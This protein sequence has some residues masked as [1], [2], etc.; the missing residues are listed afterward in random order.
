MVRYLIAGLL[1]IGGC[2]NPDR[3]LALEYPAVRV[4]ASFRENQGE[5]EDVQ[6]FR[7]WIRHPRR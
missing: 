7:L 3:R 6:K 4:E 2:S 5:R 1:L